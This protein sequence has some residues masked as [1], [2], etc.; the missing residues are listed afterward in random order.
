MLMCIVYA[1]KSVLYF[2]TIYV[3]FKKKTAMQY[4][5]LIQSV[6]SSP[7]PKYLGCG[8]SIAPRPRWSPFGKA[9]LQK[10]QY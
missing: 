7:Y 8:L 1:M 2:L 3:C 10:Q 5:N 9:C 4:K 6:A